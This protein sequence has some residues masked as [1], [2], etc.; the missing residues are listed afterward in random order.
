EYSIPLVLAMPLLAAFCVMVA[1]SAADLLG[2]WAGLELAGAAGVVMVALRR[3]DLALRLLV[4]GGMAS[5]LVLVGL[6][7]V[8]ATT[9]NPNL[10]GLR[11]VIGNE[12][13][14]LSLPIPVSVL[15]GGLAGRAGVARLAVAG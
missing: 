2:L 14:P 13:P 7:F 4:A 8:Y 15:L 1:A 6:A 11:A 10:A 9:G 3:P 12:A 5:A